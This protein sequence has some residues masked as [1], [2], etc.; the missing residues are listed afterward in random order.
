MEKNLRLSAVPS[1]FKNK[2]V[3]KQKLSEQAELWRKGGQRGLLIASYKRL[4][5]RLR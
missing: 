5:K 4:E 3:F 1:L 2:R